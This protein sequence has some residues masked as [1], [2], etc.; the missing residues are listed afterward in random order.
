MKNYYKI[1]E[2]D[3][4]ASDEI[5][6]R[7]YKV[8]VKKYHPDL[9]TEQNKEEAAK[10]ITIINEAYSILS[11]PLKRAE[12]NKKLQKETERNEKIQSETILQNEKL[13]QDDY[14]KIIQENY[15]NNQNLKQESK[16]KL[17]TNVVNNTDKILE[18][19]I[20]AA[21]K[22][23]YHD[24]YIQDMIRR[25]YKIKY[26]RDFKYYLKFAMCIIAMILIFLIIFQIPFVKQFFINLYNENIVI[27]IIVD[28]F[29]N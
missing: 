4:N 25:G 7:A 9:Q 28:I 16:P 6:E 21:R 10:R 11:N 20:N 3:K 15:I 27:K 22:K 23:A 18:E 19:Q 2:V 29:K 26:K 5:I 24:A 1:L 12:Y 17:N 8:L 13:Q 14:M